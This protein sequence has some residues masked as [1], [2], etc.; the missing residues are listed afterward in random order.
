MSR[1]IVLPRIPHIKGTR[2]SL[3]SRYCYSLIATSL[4][5]TPQLLIP[6]DPRS[7]EALTASA[8]PGSIR[9]A[10][11]VNSDLSNAQITAGNNTKVAVADAEGTANTV[12]I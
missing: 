7:N 5:L 6:N 10:P 8:F 3:N 1:A 11:E 2:Y 12:G 4:P 9:R